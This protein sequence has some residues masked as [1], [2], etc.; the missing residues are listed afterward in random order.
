MK[1]FRVIGLSVLILGLCSLLYLTS[2]DRKINDVFQRFDPVLKEHNEVLLI[3]IDDYSLN[4][5]GMWPLPRNVY[6]DLSLTLKE[7]GSAQTV[8][9][10]NFVDKGE[11]TLDD[12]FVANILPSMLDED[13]E[14][15][16]DTFVDFLS[17]VKNPDKNFAGAIEA[18]GNVFLAETFDDN[19]EVSEDEIMLLCEKALLKNVSDSGD[20]VTP[21]YAGVMPALEDFL[22]GAASSGFINAEPDADG[23]LRRIH[24]V[25]K[26]DGEY[27]GQL[28]F[29]PLLERLG[30]PE[31]QI[32]NEFI[33]LKNA[34]L[35]DGKIRDIKIV[36]SEDGSVI[37]RYP[38][39]QFES[40]NVI[41]LWNILRLQEL[42]SRL[43]DNVAV[44]DEFRYFDTLEENPL[45]LYFNSEEIKDC[46]IGNVLNTE[47]YD[48]EDYFDARI[49]LKK[50]LEYCFGGELE[51][52]L[53]DL[54]EDD[55][56]LCQDIKNQFE[57]V[58]EDYRELIESEKETKALVNNA[59]CIVGTC[60]TS[61]TDYSMNL[62]EDNYPNP[63]VHYTIANQILSQDFVDDS[64]W[65]YSFCLAVIVCA[66]YILLFFRI[67][68]T[69]AP[70]VIGLIISVLLISSVYLY[71]RFGRVYVGLAV[72]LFSLILVYIQSTFIRAL[73]DAKGR[74]FIT[75]AFSQC[76]SPD[77]VKTIIKD[78]SS[79]QLGGASRKM[80]ALFTDIQKFSTI[81]EML[82]PEQLVAFLNYYLTKMS[83]CIMEEGGTIDKFEGDAIIALVGAPLEME[84][85]AVRA[86]TAA[87]RMKSA[88]R[89]INREIVKIAG[90][91]KPAAMDQNL[92]DAFVILLEHKVKIFTR[93][94]INSGEIVAG[95]MGSDS[96]KNYTMIGNNVN[97]AA[98]LEGANKQYNTLGVL[99]SEAT[100]ELLGDI[101]VTRALDKI[102]VV[103]IKTPVQIYELIGFAK[104]SSQGLVSY[105][106]Q[107]NR[108]MKLFNE[109]NYETAL[110][111]F[112]KLKSISKTDKVVDYYIML[113]ED[114]FIKGKYPSEADGI[115]VAYNAEKNEIKG[116]FRLL[117]K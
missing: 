111:G 82:S 79:L 50:S 3:G 90:S 18:A 21:E 41:S 93:I 49:S 28:V 24:L 7:L 75:N 12:F 45:D 101:F 106:D 34:K 115:G 59:M 104:S 96:K 69:G 71:Y 17:A 64:P 77:I 14:P 84:D 83:A 61:T 98:R 2:L 94:G 112:R 19:F 66:V 113:L 29:I 97:L 92:Y 43:M 37:V 55:D 60:A 51:T 9:D 11:V 103:N 91:E 85:H 70:I 25:M 87:I 40:Y 22:S 47:E 117:Q 107:W 8:F 1:K 74:K 56:E 105:I 78:P 42:E 80:T 20:T 95:F 68:K 6:G 81:S 72:P 16:E 67:K 108:T 65:Y 5:I 4:N 54:Y 30:N 44:L 62:Y 57:V 89:E 32:S 109:E 31:I 27:Y 26:F 46:I 114:F 10:L 38:K 102:Q 86:C 76:L 116:S 15:D 88:E 39:K 36:R 100:K 33:V 35:S 23:F 53:L 48:F 13:Y 110:E 99:I 63:G 58:S 52:E 73:S